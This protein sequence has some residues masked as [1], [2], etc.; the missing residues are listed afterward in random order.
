MYVMIFSFGKLCCFKFQLQVDS[1]FLLCYLC[2]TFYLHSITIIFV[3]LLQDVEEKSWPVAILIGV[4]KFMY[5]I[6][7]RDIKIDVN[8]AKVNSTTE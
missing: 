6:I 1:F 3:C 8:I 4:G 7:M 2:L 5:N